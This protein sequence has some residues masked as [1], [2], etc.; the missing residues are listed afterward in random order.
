MK[1][2]KTI[3]V[4][5]ATGNIG[6]KLIPIL[7]QKGATVRIIGRDE[8]KLA[9]FVKLGAV[10]FVGDLTDVDFLADAFAESDA[11][12]SL[13]PPNYQAESFRGH[14][15]LV[16]DAIARA[17]VRSGV[18][19]VVNLSSLGADQTQG[20]G[21]IMGLRDQELR[22]NAIAGLNVLHLRPAYF[23]E[24]VFFGLGLIKEHGIFGTPIKSDIAFSQVGTSDIAIRA[25][26]LLLS[27]QFNGIKID[28]L[29]GPTDITMNEV[30]KTLG[31]VFEKSNLPYVQFAPADAHAAMTAS[32]LSPDVADMFLQLYDA[33][34][35]NRIK[36]V[37]GRDGENTAGKTFRAFAETTFKK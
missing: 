23:F 28:E 12:F 35:N 5:G 21:P 14:Q 37:R 25:A 24:N 20:T 9:P 2:S 8:S 27:N 33:I 18:R 19:N 11:V 7:L 31:H 3:T 36:T 29:A 1:T 4:T 10:S 32:G 6:S 30:T 34:N 17:I 16:G 15:N 13:I 22:L 26:D